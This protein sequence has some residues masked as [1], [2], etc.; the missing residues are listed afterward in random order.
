MFKH[1]ASKTTQVSQNLLTASAVAC[2]AAGFH[3]GL[4]RLRPVSEIF[5]LSVTPV[6]ASAPARSVKVPHGR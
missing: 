3:F 1:A 4:F 2:L 5:S 6:T